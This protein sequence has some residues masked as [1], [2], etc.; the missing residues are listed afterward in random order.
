MKTNLLTVIA[1]YLLAAV[2]PLAAQE[3]Q[4][5]GTMLPGY[6]GQVIPYP[7]SNTI[8]G[9]L[10][11]ERTY[12]GDKYTTT[13]HHY[14]G[15]GREVKTVVVAASPAGGNIVTERTLDCMAAIRS[16]TF[17]TSPTA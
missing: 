1:A 3:P 16:P 2:T 10:V 13:E 15:L 8:E 6:P 9:K 7:V 12:Q 17:P 5:V 14:D 4:G 11:L